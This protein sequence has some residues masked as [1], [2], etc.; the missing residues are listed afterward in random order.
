LTLLLAFPGTRED[1]RALHKRFAAN[2]ICGEWFSLNGDLL[3]W[4]QAADHSTVLEILKTKYVN[5]WDLHFHRLGKCVDECTA[6]AAEGAVE[7]APLTGKGIFR[8]G[9]PRG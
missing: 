8:S 2:W 9:N 1:E 6:R 4:V 3:E 5:E 7:R